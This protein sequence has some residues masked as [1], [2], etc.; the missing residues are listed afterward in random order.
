MLGRPSALALLCISLTA[1]FLACGADDEPTPSDDDDD[2]TS[3]GSGGSS[4]SD[5]GGPASSGAGASGA[6]SSSSGTGASGGAAGCA[7]LGDACSDCAAAQCNEL[8]CTC[9]DNASC[10]ALVA[11]AQGCAAG[12]TDCAQSCLSNNQS[13]ISDALLL[14][15][16]AATSC[17]QACP[18]ATTLGACEA[19]AFENC[20]SQM[21][22][23]LADAECT[24]LIQCVQ[25]CNGDDLC[26]YGC[27]LDHGDGQQAAE[28]VQSCVAQP[29]P[30]CG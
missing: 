13:G 29:C 9:Y 27:V 8:Y 3:S 18:A 4:S 25:E 24:A 14:G 28:A 7:G 15:N 12:D 10:G 1:L 21:N 30:S 17:A 5:G 23:C 11:C 22:T 16:C 6:S 2:T 26:N 20:P 19:C